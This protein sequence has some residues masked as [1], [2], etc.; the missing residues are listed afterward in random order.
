MARLTALVAVVEVD[1]LERG[2]VHRQLLLAYRL[3]DVAR[4]GD[5]HAERLAQLVVV[6][7]ELAMLLDDLLDHDHRIVPAGDVLG[8]ASR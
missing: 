4:A 7:A 2:Q 6:E 1:L 3:G 8:R 5:E